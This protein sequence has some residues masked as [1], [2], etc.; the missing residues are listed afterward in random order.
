M[1]SILIILVFLLARDEKLG[2]EAV[3]HLQASNPDAKNKVQFH[4][5]DITNVESIHRLADDIKRKHGGL[6]ILINNAAMAFKV[7]EKNL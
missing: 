2:L 6:D 4:Q 3:Q 7:I 5:L 1:H